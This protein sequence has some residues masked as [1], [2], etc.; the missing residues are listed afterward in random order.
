MRLGWVLAVSLLASAPARADVWAD[1]ATDQRAVGQLEFTRLDVDARKR[2]LERDS[3]DLAAQIERVKSDTGVRR[4]AKLQE[5][6]AAQK[7][8]SDELERLASEARSRASLLGGARKKLIAD[9]DRALA[10][11]S[12]PEAKRLELARLRTTQAAA[13]ATPEKPI[14][15]A[16]AADDPLD[17]PR[18]LQDK[19]DLLRDSGDKLRREV[20]RLAQ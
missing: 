12:L 8:K 1:L 4:D 5:L 14:G 13:L 10:A 11:P 18:E 9:C 2:Q 16:R 20:Q 19:A 3:D 17:G 15:V 7:A 6:L